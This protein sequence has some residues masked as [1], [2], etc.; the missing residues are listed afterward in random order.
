MKIV[1]SVGAIS[2]ICT[3]ATAGDQSIDGGTSTDKP[4]LEAIY[5]ASQSLSPSRWRYRETEWTGDPVADVPLESLSHLLSSSIASTSS[6]MKR[7]H[8]ECETLRA[9]RS[10]STLRLDFYHEVLQSSTLRTL[11]HIEASGFLDWD[12]IDDKSVHQQVTGNSIDM[13]CAYA[14]LYTGVAVTRGSFGIASYDL[15]WAIDPIPCRPD[16]SDLTTQ[17]W[18]HAPSASLSFTI[19]PPGFEGQRVP[20]ISGTLAEGVP[21]PTHASVSDHGSGKT[22]RTIDI[23]WGLYPGGIHP[24]AIWRVS[25]DRSGDRRLCLIETVSFDRVAEDYENFKPKAHAD[26]RITIEQPVQEV[27][28]LEDAPQEVKDMLRILPARHPRRRVLATAAGNGAWLDHMVVRWG[29]IILAL[30]LCMGSTIVYR[31]YFQSRG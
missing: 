15:R 12:S 18:I 24:V 21:L 14:P 3:A 25:E 19:D 9:E 31:R 10:T 16:W 1:V 26:S 2:L 5:C 7:A 13:V 22:V 23:E 20:W 17:G 30:A 6:D 29:V 11:R 8:A 4:A 27:V 28:D